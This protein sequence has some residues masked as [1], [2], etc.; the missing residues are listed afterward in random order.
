MEGILV[1]VIAELDI[2]NV[3]LFLCIVLGIWVLLIQHVLPVLSGIFK[4][5]QGLLSGLLSVDHILKVWY[6]AGAFGDWSVI[7]LLPHFPL[8]DDDVGETDA[9]NE[10]GDEV[11]SIVDG[12]LV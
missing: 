2:R 6:F 12:L 1:T 9:D 3:F 10:D 4:L 11:D 5:V 8:L 7:F